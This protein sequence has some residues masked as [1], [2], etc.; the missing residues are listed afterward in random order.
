MHAAGEDYEQEAEDDIDILKQDI[1][2]CFLAV[3]AEA[4]DPRDAQLIADTIDIET[5]A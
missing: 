5:G 3:G 2:A 4:D 1:I